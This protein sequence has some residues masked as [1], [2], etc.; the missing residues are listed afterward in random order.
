MTDELTFPDSVKLSSELQNL[1]R[2]LLEKHPMNRTGVRSGIKEIFRHTWFKKI[3]MRDLLDKKLTPP[4]IPN[5]L[6]FNF[7]EGEYSNGEKEYRKKLI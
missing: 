2:G 5:V 4:I 1:L 6:A 3:N 7:D